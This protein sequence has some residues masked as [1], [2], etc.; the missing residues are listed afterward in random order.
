M[1]KLRFRSLFLVS[2]LAV[3]GCGVGLGAGGERDRGERAHVVRAVDGDTI[4]A[5]TSGGREHYVRLLGIDTPETV[6]PGTP[7]ECGGE[8]AT[9]NLKAL[10]PAGAAL[11][12]TS[13]PSQDRRDRYGRL[14]RYAEIE[15]RDL[16]RAQLAE[17]SAEPYTYEPSGPV[18]RAGSY[19]R[20]AARA[21]SAGRGVWAECGGDF[22]ARLSTGAHP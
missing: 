11:R 12:L 1:N 5:R 2:A 19:E 14:L 22:H 16:G 6:A 17:G 8:A 18:A 3:G 9:A 20:A 10:A 7:P 21:E 4:V 13:D 15:G